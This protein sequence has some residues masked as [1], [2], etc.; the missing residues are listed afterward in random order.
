[1]GMV[2]GRAKIAD[3]L[4]YWNGLGLQNIDII[5]TEQRHQHEFIVLWPFACFG[6]D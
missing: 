5:A 1:M 6:L 2:E 3:V 4:A